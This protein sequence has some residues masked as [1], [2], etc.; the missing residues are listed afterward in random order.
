MVLAVVSAV[1]EQRVVIIMVSVI[2]EKLPALVPRTAVAQLV[3]HPA[4]TT[5]IPIA[6]PVTIQSVL[7]AVILIIKAVLMAA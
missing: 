3:V 4:F 6:L 2:M 1:V 5:I 7:M